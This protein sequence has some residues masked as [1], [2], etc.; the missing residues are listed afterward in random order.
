MVWF[1]RAWWVLGLRMVN[2]IFNVVAIFK[3]IFKFFEQYIINIYGAA[4][5]SRIPPNLNAGLNFVQVNPLKYLYLKLLLDSTVVQNMPPRIT[6]FKLKRL[7]HSKWYRLPLATAPK[8]IWAL[9]ANKRRVMEHRMQFI[10]NFT[11]FTVLQVY[12]IIPLSGRSNLVR[13]YL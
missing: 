6:F 3:F 11:E 12:I 1:G 8:V 13:R 4:C 7:T 5:N 10:P 2:R 9:S